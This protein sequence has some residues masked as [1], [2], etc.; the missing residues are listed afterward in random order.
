VTVAAAKPTPVVVSTAKPAPVA[1]ATV[2]PA[3]AAGAAA[4]KSAPDAIP[5]A[6]PALVAI[7]AAKPAP[8]RL[9][10]AATAAAEPVVVRDLVHPKPGDAYLQVGAYAAPY[11]AGW[12]NTLQGRGFHPIVAEGPNSSIHRVLIGPLA[13]AQVSQVEAKLRQAGIEHFEKVY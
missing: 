4:G 10:P 13:P 6:R 1:V 3:P 7:A 11:V 5:A 9:A 12:V 8:A 2:K